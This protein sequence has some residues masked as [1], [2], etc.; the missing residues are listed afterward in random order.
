M[1]HH[2]TCARNEVEQAFVPVL[3]VRRLVAA[4][5]SSGWRSTISQQCRSS[6]GCG[7]SQPTKALT[8]QRTAMPVLH[9]VRSFAKRE[10]LA[11]IHSGKLY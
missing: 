10:W 8:G 2:A 5:V 9:C 3:G 1:V 6:K 7:E 11:V 4:L